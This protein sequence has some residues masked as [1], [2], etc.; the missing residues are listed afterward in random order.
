MSNKRLCTDF[1]YT[2]YIIRDLEK[3][4]K[5][6]N[7]VLSALYLNKKINVVPGSRPTNEGIRLHIP[8]YGKI[9][10]K[11]CPISIEFCNLSKY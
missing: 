8:F 3:Y 7:G 11:N 6:S 1:E 5:T 10:N 2:E 4:F 9:Y